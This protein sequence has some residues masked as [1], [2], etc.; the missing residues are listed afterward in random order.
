M[1]E[2]ALNPPHAERV[3]AR[4]LV[5]ACVSCRGYIEPDADNPAAEEFRTN[6]AQWV[7]DSGL[8]PE[9][10]A[11]ERDLLNTP[12]GRLNDQQLVTDAAWAGEG[13]A[14]LAWALGIRKLP[15]Y[16]ESPLPADVASDLGFMKS[17]SDTAL[18]S[19]TLRNEH[20]I[21]S[22][23][24]FMFALHWRLR[25]F[26]LNHQPM[27]FR[28]FAA[29]AWF[30]PLRTEGMKFVNEDLALRGEAI[31]EADPD[32][33]RVCLSLAMERHKAVNWLLGRSEIY[34]ETGADT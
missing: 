32:L 33:S 15:P 3:A 7:L 30:G 17:L 14:V 8:G 6:V 2:E 25:Q 5:L 28:E 29:T 22:F 23:S 11:W 31:S 4:A 27:N 21:R 16:D 10:E 19:P 34:S 9:L 26:H 24:D 18:V 1:E 20:E 13:C 12:L